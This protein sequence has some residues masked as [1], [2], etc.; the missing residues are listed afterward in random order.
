[1]ELGG[2]KILR[3]VTSLQQRRVVDLLRAGV[4]HPHEMAS[5]S[6]RALDRFWRR[7]PIQSGGWGDCT[8]RGIK[9]MFFHLV[10]LPLK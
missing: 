10:M 8:G 2:G 7:A 5:H 4:R 9:R 1:M 6:S 3:L